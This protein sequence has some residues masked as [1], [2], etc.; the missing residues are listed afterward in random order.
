MEDEIPQAGRSGQIMAE[1]E[2][3]MTFA[4]ALM[5]LMHGRRVSAKFL[6][7]NIFIELQRPDK[8]SMNTEP[9]LK[10]VTVCEPK[11]GS[12]TQFAPYVSACEP[13]E[14][15]RRSLFCGDWGLSIWDRK[16]LSAKV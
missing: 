3:L 13:W 9:Y 1:D 7:S 10:M 12:T 2:S 6:P 4:E 11:P 15:G 8:G 14:P 16:E 5:Q